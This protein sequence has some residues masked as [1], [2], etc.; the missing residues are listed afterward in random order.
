MLESLVPAILE[1]K[2]T[3]EAARAAYRGLVGLHGERA[4]GPLGL[5]LPPPATVLS[6]LPYHAYHPLGVERRRA[7]LIRAVSRDARR[8]EATAGE[9]LPAA[10]ARLR[11]IPGI[12]PWTAAEVGLRAYGDR[13]AVSVGDFHLKNLVVFAFTGRPRGSDDEMLELL[14]PFRGQ[15]GRVVR[16]LELSGHPAA[17]VRPAVVAAAYRARLSRQAQAGINVR[18]GVGETAGETADDRSAGDRPTTSGRATAG[19]GSG[20][21]GWPGCRSRR[22]PRA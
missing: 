11:A 21:C 19:T 4:P 15:R 7:D 20:R 2:V 9:D 22:T 16:L 6:R 12:G 3:G 10:Y 8:L 5:R 18:R 17:G 13:D 1:Q 14:E